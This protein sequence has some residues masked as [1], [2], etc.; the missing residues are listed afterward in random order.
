VTA[1]T[2][3]LQ[4]QDNS[5]SGLAHAQPPAGPRLRMLSEGRSKR[6]IKLI[7]GYDRE[8]RRCAKV[9]AYHAA[10]ILLGAQL[11]GMLLA[12]C[13]MYPKEVRKWFAQQAPKRRPKT[14]IDQWRLDTL[15]RVARDLGWLPT[16]SNSRAPRKVGDWVDLLREL[17]NLVHPGKHL[18]DYPKIRISKLHLSDAEAV[19]DSAHGWLLSKVTSDLKRAIEREE[20][21]KRTHR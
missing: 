18:R 9:R 7:N 1:T 15:S 21:R 4:L 19:F 13:A 5:V 8:V 16:R 10:C 6:L 11:E 14:A 17:R 3:N 12:M 20:R 2:D